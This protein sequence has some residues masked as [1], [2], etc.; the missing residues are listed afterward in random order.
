MMSKTDQGDAA[1]RAGGLSAAAERT[2]IVRGNTL[3]SRDLFSA[4]REL[5][6]SHGSDTYRL[7]LTSQNKLI[8]TK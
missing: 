1:K 4:G 7:R 2:M 8:L 6:I 3:D 5:I